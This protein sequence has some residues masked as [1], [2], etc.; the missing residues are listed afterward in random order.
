MEQGGSLGYGEAITDDMLP[1]GGRYGTA[2]RYLAMACG[3]CCLGM[4][5]QRCRAADSR[6]AYPALPQEAACSAE[7]RSARQQQGV[8]E[9]GVVI[10]GCGT[11]V[12]ARTGLDGVA[13]APFGFL[14]ENHNRTTGI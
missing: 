9:K 6:V 13:T 8:V 4:G 7:H 11:R 3:G 14:F 2:C 5:V 1:K 10:V 12:N